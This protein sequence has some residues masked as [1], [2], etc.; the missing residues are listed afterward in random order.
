MTLFCDSFLLFLSLLVRYDR[1]EPKYDYR[2][3]GFSPETGQF[4]QVI[5]INLTNRSL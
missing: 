5:E 4:T 3:P 1:E 2:N